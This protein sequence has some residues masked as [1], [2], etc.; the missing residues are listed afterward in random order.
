MHV[1][2]L[3]QESF[4]SECKGLSPKNIGYV[5]EFNFLEHNFNSVKG[6][7]QQRSFRSVKRHFRNCE[8]DL[9]KAAGRALDRSIQSISSYRTRTFEELHVLVQHVTFPWQNLT[10]KTVQDCNMTFPMW[11]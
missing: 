10:S 5:R 7:L 2:G 11:L 9:P 4:D 3:S 8:A 6:P 1:N